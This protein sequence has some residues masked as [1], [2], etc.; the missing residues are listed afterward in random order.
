M[1]N[2]TQFREF[3]SPILLVSIR[4]YC[5]KYLILKWNTNPFIFDIVHIILYINYIEFPLI[6]ICKF[7][8]C[9]IVNSDRNYKCHMLIFQVTKKVQLISPNSIDIQ[10]QFNSDT[11]WKLQNVIRGYFRMIQILLFHIFIFTRKNN[12][13]NIPTYSLNGNDRETPCIS[14]RPSTT[15]CR[16]QADH[17]STNTKCALQ[18]RPQHKDQPTNHFRSRRS[19][20]MK[21]KTFR[22]DGFNEI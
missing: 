22:V 3:A 14:G 4:I 17:T 2:E 9:N 10:Q 6:F 15:L 11:K 1:M 19:P 7:I 21:K 20:E 12:S 13:E 16:T 5:M 8:Y 18:S